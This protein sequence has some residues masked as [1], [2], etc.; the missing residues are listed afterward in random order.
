M[1]KKPSPIEEHKEPDI[2]QI[3]ELQ[4]AIMEST[5]ELKCPHCNK[6]FVHQLVDIKNKIEASKLLS[7]LH[8]ALQVDRIV[9]TATT[10]AQQAMLVKPELKPE[11]KEKLNKLLNAP[12]AS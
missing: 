1:T 7:R 2:K 4:L 9:A 6:T 11:L 3:R 8:K 5:G 12:T 10:T